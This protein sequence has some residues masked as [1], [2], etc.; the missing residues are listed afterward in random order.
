MNLFKPKRLEPFL[1]VVREERKTP[2]AVASINPHPGHTL[3]KFA[4]SGRLTEVTEDEYEQ[5]DYNLNG[6]N[7]RKLIREKGCLYLSAL[8][9]KNATRKLRQMGV[10]K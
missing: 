10:V 2:E 9:I 8:N 5:T 1:S 3:F 6:G 7:S 4:P